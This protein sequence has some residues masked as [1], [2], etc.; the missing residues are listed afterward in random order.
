MCY[1]IVLMS[2]LL[3]YNVEN[4]KNKEIPLNES[5][6]ELVLY[7]L[8]KE[9]IKHVYN[10]T[11]SWAKGAICKA[12]LALEDDQLLSLLCRVNLA[13]AYTELTE[14]LVLNAA[15]Y[16]MNSILTYCRCS[17]ACPVVLR[18]CQ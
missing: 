9:T 15:L 7:A 8:V 14:E 12:D 3:F 16:P 2:S 5:V 11:P 1:F 18:P 13:L 6:N 4:S 10:D 17:L